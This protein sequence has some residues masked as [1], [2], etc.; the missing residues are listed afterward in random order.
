MHTDVRIPKTNPSASIHVD[1]WLFRPELVDDVVAWIDPGP[2][3]TNP[4]VQMSSSRTA[5]GADRG[6]LAAAGD[7]IT[8][9]HTQRTAVSVEGVYAVAMVNL[10]A[11]TPAAF[12]A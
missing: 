5:R 1:Q 9:I 4:V 11:T 7:R 12:P 10:D 2:T 3:A 8:D 6:D